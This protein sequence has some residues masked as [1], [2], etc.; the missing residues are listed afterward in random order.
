MRRFLRRIRGCGLRP[1]RC[2]S[3]AVVLRDSVEDRG[4]SAIMSNVLPV[5][6]LRME[7]ER[8]RHPLLPYVR[9][10]DPFGRVQ[11]VAAKLDRI[12]PS[13]SPCSSSLQL[14]V[15]SCERALHPPAAECRI[16][17]H[18]LG[19]VPFFQWNTFSPHKA[20]QRD[21]QL[22]FFSVAFVDTGKQEDLIMSIQAS[23]RAGVSAWIGCGC[24]SENLEV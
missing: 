6:N 8:R 24:N 16:L 1:S 22:N 9:S 5:C 12:G 21:L 10:R 20:S 23:D 2:C 11:W 7:Q 14:R 4:G 15:L 3:V 18:R 19:T 13:F 17:S